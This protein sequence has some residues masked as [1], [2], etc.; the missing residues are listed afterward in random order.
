MKAQIYGDNEQMQLYNNVIQ[1]QHKLMGQTQ[2]L[3]TSN[4][5]NMAFNS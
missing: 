5:K 3:Y 1:N 2:N 4:C